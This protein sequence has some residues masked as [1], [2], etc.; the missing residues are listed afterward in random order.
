MT[1]TLRGRRRRSV[2]GLVWSGLA[3]GL[4]ACGAP[5]TERTE[6]GER[7]RIEET[8]ILWDT[9][10]VPHIFARTD[11]E[12]FY[13][14]AWAQMRAHSDLML[15]L[16]GA[17]RGRAAEY[18]GEER[19]ESDRWV[20][21]MG[22]PA[23]AEAW[24]EAQR[25]ASRALLDAFAAGVNGYAERHPDRIADEV[26]VVLPVRPTDLLAHLQRDIHFSFVTAPWLVEGAVRRW[27]EGG[28]RIS[29]SDPDNAAQPTWAGSNAWALGP[30][31]TGS[32]HAMLLS[33]PH[34]PWSD[35]FVWFEAQLVS[36]SVDVYGATL[37]GTT[38]PGIA[39]NE[40]LGW[41]HTVNALDGQDLYELTLA[42]GGYVWDGEVRPF[43]V[44]MEIL[45]VRR[46]EGGWREE[47]LEVR[48]SV[49]GPVVAEDGGRALALRV[50]GLDQP[51]IGEQYWEMMRAT[52]LEAFEAALA[53]LQM[54]IFTVMYADRDGHIMHLFGGR[55]P[56]RPAGDW[57]WAG[58]V[59]GDVSVTFWDEV[60][61]YGEL[62][63]VADPPS[64]W[65][66]NAND[67]PWT[68]TFPR[69]LEPDAYPPYM[70]PRAMAFRP[71]R[72]ARM[73]MEDDRID[74][75][76]LVRYKHS[77]RM[78][79]ADRLLDELLPAARALG[80]DVARRA[81]EVLKA[82]DRTADADSRGG[83]LF[84]SFYDAARR[85]GRLFDLSWDPE[86][87]MSTPDGLA[88][89]ERAVAILER[90]ASELEAAHGSLDVAWGELHRLRR[91]AL[92]LPSNGGS[93]A[94]GIFRVVS[95]REDDDGLLRAGSGDSYVAAVEFSTPLRARALIGYG[96]WSQP[97][98]P[99]RTDQLELF[100]RKELRPVWRTREEITLHLEERETPSQP[101]RVT[102]W[103]K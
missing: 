97:G 74:F 85:S 39:F 5:S 46:P 29:S 22:I 71:Q 35:L 19:L 3:I 89:P 78:E 54:P 6:V 64:G 88:E 69:A 100:A 95:Y 11:E 43:E 86:A 10:G 80:G 18:W 4:A 96:N 59:P 7:P 21:T 56:V 45:R 38:F 58:I 50:V 27:K 98:S 9:Y 103:N 99:H 28:G 34:L 77:T 79:V 91:D 81:A 68:T 63:R 82:W 55:T 31:R 42:D 66:Q 65:L 40:H 24:Y 30:S 73:L 13:A 67:P 37:V 61:A 51:G 62:P 17:A 57:D 33:N 52:D 84:V 49:H 1:E 48:E 41:T 12:L 90:V 60:H 83:V 53:R 23:R 36:P 76:D 70:A 94:Y 72:S 87:P 15:Q 26:A 8:E 2:A 32:G 101:S 25:P 92:D 14:Y 102:M 47:T 20:R 16:Y 93:G 75:E 44:R